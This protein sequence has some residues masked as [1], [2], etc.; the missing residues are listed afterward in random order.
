ME[1]FFYTPNIAPKGNNVVRDYMECIVNDENVTK[2]Q[3]F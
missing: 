1:R 3:I 2:V